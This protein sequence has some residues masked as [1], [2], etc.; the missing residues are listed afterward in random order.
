MKS[1]TLL[2]NTLLLILLASPSLAK[3]LDKSTDLRILGNELLERHPIIKEYNHKISAQ[4]AHTKYA[5]SP[6]DPK[7]GVE[8]VTNDFP[9]NFGS[10]GDLPN[11]MLK[12]TASKELKV[13]G[14]LS[15]IEK[16]ESFET[17]KLEEDLKLSKLILRS[18][19]KQKYYELFFLDKSFEIYNKILELLY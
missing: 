1:L 4:K 3:E 9:G 12:L 15:L 8:L 5:Q 7:L 17:Q 13:L 2:F 11:N 16:A 10:I 6:S 19:L 18:E 14:K